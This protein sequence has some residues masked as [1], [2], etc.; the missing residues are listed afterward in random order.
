MNKKIIT[1]LLTLV[2]VLTSTTLIN[3]AS[4]EEKPATV[5]ILDTAIDS[6][7]PIFKNKLVYEVCI[8][9]F[10]SCPNKKNFMEGP[11][12][13]LLPLNHL[14]KNGFDHGTQMA[15]I[16]INENPNINF[17]FVRIIGNTISG[18]RQLTPE[19]TIS[20]ALNWVENNRLKFNIQAVTMSQGHHNLLNSVNYC[21]KTNNT[22]LAVSRLKSVGV[23]VFFPAGN[24]RDYKRIDW[25]AC[26]P[27]SVAVGGSSRED[28]IASFGNYDNNLIDFFAPAYRTAYLPGG[29]TINAAGTS[30]SVQVAAA[31]WLKI[32]SL[33]PNEDTYSLILLKAK[34]IVGIKGMFGKMIDLEA[35]LNG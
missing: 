20:N 19:S 15:S 6:T 26:L 18:D 35:S 16:L 1:A 5:A 8:L 24:G 34:N 27:N 23:P 2:L 9:A 17:V 4:A 12:A 30:V 7:L 22:D 29:K 33:K 21:P 11:G 28:E 13:A 10:N 31:Q 14:S 3:K 25:P 32:K